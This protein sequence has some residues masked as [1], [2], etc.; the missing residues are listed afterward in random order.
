MNVVHRGP[1]LRDA[2]PPAWRQSLAGGQGFGTE[3][4]DSSRFPWVRAGEDLC[5][6]VVIVL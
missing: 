3:I 5:E 2:V 1:A 4:S 6:S